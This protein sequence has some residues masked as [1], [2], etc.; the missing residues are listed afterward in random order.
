MNFLWRKRVI[1]D[2]VRVFS[3]V[4]CC[5]KSS[6]C[7]RYA[8][9]LI[10]RLHAAQLGP[11][12]SQP[13]SNTVPQDVQRVSLNLDRVH[14]VLEDIYCEEAL[15]ESCDSLF[16]LHRSD[17]EA[18]ELR[19]KSR[20]AW[21]THVNALRSKQEASDHEQNNVSANMRC[22]CDNLAFFNVVPITCS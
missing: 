16:H 4:S 20:R 18:G 22:R 11:L 2:D 9:K 12:A 3:S 7:R 17:H 21:M 15:F 19:T 1:A 10:A 8:H 14:G 5:L 6:S 13:L